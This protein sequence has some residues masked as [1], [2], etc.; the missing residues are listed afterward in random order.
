MINT[1]NYINSNIKRG[2]PIAP[3]QIEVPKNKIKID[4]P[5]YTISSREESQGY[6]SYRADSERVEV[7]ANVFPVFL[8]A[9]AALV[10]LTTIRRFVEE[11]R[12]NIGTF[13]ALGYGNGSIAIKF[14][15]YSTSAAIL[16]A[17]LGY[18]FL[19]NLIIKAYLASSTLGSDY[20]LSFAWGP[21]LISLIIACYYCCFHAYA[22]SNAKRKARRIA[23]AKATEEWFSHFARTYSLAMEAYEFFCQ[24]YCTKHLPL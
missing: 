10:S 15:L 22:L 24:S 6:S 7:L 18:T 12:T 19:P 13:K 4:Y 2:I 11:E 23:F 16:G 21:L 9:V 1:F 5:S 14:L 8:F 3:G 17:S 20:Q